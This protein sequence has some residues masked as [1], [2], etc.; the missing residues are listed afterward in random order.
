MK[1]VAITYDDAYPFYTNQLLDILDRYQVKATFFEIN[2]NNIEK[3][4]EIVKMIVARGEELANH[5]YS[6]KSQLPSRSGCNII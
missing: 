4:Q 1:V 3:H 6:H 2:R 5:S